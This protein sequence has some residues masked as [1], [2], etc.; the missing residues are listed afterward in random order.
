MGQM[1]NAEGGEVRVYNMSSTL[2]YSD[3]Q[4]W[5]Y[6]PEQTRE[7][8]FVFRHYTNADNVSFGQSKR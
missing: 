3:K 7:E 5:Y 1:V 6:Y 2:V 4:K 8:L